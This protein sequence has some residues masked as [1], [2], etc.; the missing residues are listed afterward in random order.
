MDKPNKRKVRALNLSENDKKKILDKYGEGLQPAQI[1]KF[2][3]GKYTYFQIYN[4]INP[5]S[6]S[7]TTVN[8]DGSLKEVKIKQDKTV[9]EMPVID[10]A[11][12]TSIEKFIEHQLTVIIT[13]LNE[14]KIPL[15]KRIL[16]TRSITKINYEL[17]KQLLE[18]HLKN[19]NAKL[20]IRIMRR[21]KPELADEEILTVFKEESEK[22]KK[23][24]K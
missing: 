22:M 10:L 12:F 13:Q 11:D 24:N 1:E 7:S 3:E 17:K 18:N 16:L 21:L 20:I 14:K 6:A 8:Q 19:A 9:T 15:E 2:F 4:T 23:L 5:R